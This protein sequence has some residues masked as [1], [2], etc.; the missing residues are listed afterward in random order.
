MLDRVVSTTLDDRVLLENVEQIQ[1]KFLGERAQWYPSWP[2]GGTKQILPIA[3][4]VTIQIKE[5]GTIERIFMVSAGQI[6]V[7]KE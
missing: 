3:V 6:N 4:Q 1:W 2:S 5:W 7:T